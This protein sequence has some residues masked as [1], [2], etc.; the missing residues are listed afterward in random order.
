VY[1]GDP[2]YGC[3]GCL[4]GLCILLFFAVLFVAALSV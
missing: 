2:A 3:C 4:M 1:Y